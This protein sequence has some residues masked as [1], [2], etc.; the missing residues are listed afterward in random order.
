M[1]NSFTRPTPKLDLDELERAILVDSHTISRC[2]HFAQGKQSFIV[3][4][5][6]INLFQY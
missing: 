3:D 2:Q 6:G 4:S 5:K 1:S